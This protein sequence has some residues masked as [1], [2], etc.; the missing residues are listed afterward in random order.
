MNITRDE[1]EQLL[2]RPGL[3]EA[4]TEW[5]RKRRPGELIRVAEAHGV[6]ISVEEGDAVEHQSVLR[7]SAGYS[8]RAVRTHR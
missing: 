7:Q 6:A 3:R 5:E 1:A 8:A 4:L 2:R